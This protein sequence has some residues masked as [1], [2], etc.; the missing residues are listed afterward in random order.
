M[1]HCKYTILLC[2]FLIF[3]VV[4]SLNIRRNNGFKTTG[5]TSYEFQVSVPL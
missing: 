3:T 5:E 1:A 2:L 4:V